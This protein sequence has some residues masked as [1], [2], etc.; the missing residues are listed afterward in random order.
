[1]KPVK[2]NFI[3][4]SIFLVLFLISI[5]SFVFLEG[6]F[7]SDSSQK[8]PIEIETAVFDGDTVSGYF[9]NSGQD[10]LENFTITVDSSPKEIKITEKLKPGEKKSYRISGISKPDKIIVKASNWPSTEEKSL[11]YSE[12]RIE[13]NNNPPYTITGKLFDRTKDYTKNRNERTGL[14]EGG[15]NEFSGDVKEIKRSFSTDWD[16][17][18]V[19]LLDEEGNVVASDYT[20]N[21]GEYELNIGST[22]NYTVLAAGLNISNTRVDG[23][24]KI[25]FD[26]TGKILKNGIVKKEFDSIEI[27]ECEGE[28]VVINTFFPVI[29]GERKIATLEQ[30]QCIGHNTSTLKANYSLTQDV[31]ASEEEEILQDF[32]SISSFDG[33]LNGKDHEIK[34]LSLEIRY[35]GGLIKTNKGLIKNIGVV[36]IVANSANEGGI[37]VGT[38]KGSIINSYSTGKLGEEEISSNVGGLVGINKGS[39]KDSHTTVNISGTKNLGSLV[40]RNTGKIED[41]YSKSNLKGHYN[42]GGLIGENKGSVKS[43]YSAA[44][45]HCL[46]GE[47]NPSTCNAGG[48]IGENFGSVNTSYSTGQISK[49]KNHAGG[50]IGE[51]NGNLSFS[52]SKVTVSGQWHVGGLVG[53]NNQGYIENSYSRGDV[54]GKYNVGGLVGGN[55]GAIQKTYSTGKVEGEKDVGGLLGKDYKDEEESKPSVINSYWNKDSSN[56]LKSAGSKANGLNNS[57]IKGSRAKTNMEGF[58]FDKIW[59]TVDK[60]DK[61]I[62]ENRYPI[63]EIIDSKKQL[64]QPK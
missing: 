21:N 49:G 23:F 38:N 56:Q 53:L 63:L 6:S 46:V 52:F 8:N 25:D 55:F 58:N 32:T 43:S 48:L 17:V 51:N 30:L 26:M 3:Y 1:M 33:N 18:R 57:Q 54:S 59:R 61:I 62:S 19:K 12:T 50:L 35:S 45:I 64:N 28:S 34:G 14:D 9:K 39:I 42:V 40:A 7:I 27:R 29:E 15:Q 4:P 16:N 13:K 2:T 41:S 44:N 31:D 11:N 24:T 22:G 20:D 37:L 5:A 36:N 47:P 60:N 10:K